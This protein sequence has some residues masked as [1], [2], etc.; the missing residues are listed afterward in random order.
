MT[1]IRVRKDGNY[2]TASNEP[3]V[4][5]RLSW[6]TRGMIGYLL[7][8][9]N[10]WETRIEDLKKQGPAKLHKIRR[11]LAEARAHGYINRIRIT[12]P[13]GT[14]S[15]ITEVYES[16][17][18][19]PNPSQSFN[20]TSVRKSTTGQENSTSVR[21]STSG[22]STSGKP[23]DIVSTDLINTELTKCNIKSVV[24][25]ATK[26]KKPA[27]A[28]SSGEKIKNPFYKDNL[29]M[30]ARMAITQ[31]TADKVANATP[32]SGVLVDPDFIRQHVETL[33]LGESLGLA[34]HRI[35]GGEAPRP[36]P[37]KRQSFTL[38]ELR[39]I[40]P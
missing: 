6:E 27:T 34:I 30:C 37:T 17:S 33:A 1:I 15:W 25:K 19:N 9:P 39:G 4:D 2:F 10:N 16:P 31:P 22:S 24:V 38:E 12:N 20:K 35:L 18:Q 26:K 36:Y 8:K 21:L 32:L 3:F 5:P 13:E 28:T 40:Q 11:M 29:A 23:A 14:F 7:T